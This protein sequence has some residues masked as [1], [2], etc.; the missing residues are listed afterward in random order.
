MSLN[1][2]Q[3]RLALKPITLAAAVED[4]VGWLDCH[5]TYTSTY[6]SAI[7]RPL[8]SSKHVCLR[9]SQLA[10]PDLRS[11]IKNF[12]HQARSQ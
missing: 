2:L 8:A 9:R 10:C 7:H 4:I 1:A 12:A 3:R 6:T 5:G 11:K